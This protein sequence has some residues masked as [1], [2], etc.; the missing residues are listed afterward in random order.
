[1]AS[2]YHG[3]SIALIFGVS[4]S[5]GIVLASL[6]RSG[7]GSRVVSKPGTKHDLHYRATPC[8]SFVIYNVVYTI[9]RD[10]AVRA[11]DGEQAWVTECVFHAGQ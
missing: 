4:V 6:Q 8:S 3:L 11:R 9:H 10:G 7:L 2:K 5:L 1:M